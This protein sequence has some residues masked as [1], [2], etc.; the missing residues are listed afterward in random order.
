V[1]KRVAVIII[2][3]TTTMFMVL[4]SMQLLYNTAYDRVP[5]KWLRGPGKVLEFF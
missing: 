1:I 3:I 4:S 2:I 5:E